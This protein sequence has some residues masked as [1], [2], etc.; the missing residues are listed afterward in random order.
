MIA[1]AALLREADAQRFREGGCPRPGGEHDRSRPQRAL[2][3]VDRDP[4]VRAPEAAHLDM[5]LDRRARLLRRAAGGVDEGERIA[6]RLVGEVDAA[7]DALAYR[8]LEPPCLVAVEHLRRHADPVS[9]RAGLGERGFRLVHVEDAAALEPGCEA[10]VRELGVELQAGERELRMIRVP[11]AAR[12]AVDALTKR[13]SQGATD[14][15]GRRKKGLSGESIQRRPFRSEAGFAIGAEWLG[16]RRPAFPDEAPEASSP[17]RSSSVTA[18]PRRAS[19]SAQQTPIAPPPSSRRR[20]AGR[21][22]GDRAREWAGEEDDRGGDLVGPG[23]TV[24]AG[25]GG[26]RAR[27]S[28]SRRTPRSSG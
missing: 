1:L 11:S 9:V 19:W 21:S 12:D 18:A 10:F 20:P 13:A 3:R 8:G 2:A 26:R 28:R 16:Q 5:R 24:R 15:R 27:R 17:P 23:A 4:A 6:V 7:G 22:P 14:G 25:C